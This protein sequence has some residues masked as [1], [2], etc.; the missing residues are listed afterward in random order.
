MKLLE[1]QVFGGEGHLTEVA[2]STLADGQ[3]D[4]I[5]TAGHAHLD[6]CAHCTARFEQAMLESM[7]IASTLPI[8]AAH[9]ESAR[10]RPPWLWMLVASVGFVLLRGTGALQSLLANAPITERRMIGWTKLGHHTLHALRDIDP[11]L[12]ATSMLSTLFLVMLLARWLRDDPAP[13]R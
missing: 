11:T 13:S 4:L 6:A 12:I 5:D 10:T 9:E 3:L 7:Q 1:S 8:L 2:L